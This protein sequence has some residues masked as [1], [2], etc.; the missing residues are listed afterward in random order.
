MESTISKSRIKLIVI[1]GVIA[2]SFGSIIIK[3]SNAPAIIIS[4]YR[5]FFTVLILTP[6]I[7]RDTSSIEEIKSI[8]R[9]NLILCILSGFF[10][11]MHFATWITSLKYTSINSSTIL[12]NTHPIFIVLISFFFIKKRYSSKAI[13]AIVI[14]ITGGILI[15]WGDMSMGRVQ[16][17]GDILALLGGFF[18]SGYILLGNY[19]RKDLSAK[20]YCY[21][22]YSF[23]VL[24]L[25]LITLFMGHS[26]F[27]YSLL[28]YTRFFGLAFICTILGH[29]VFNWALAYIDASF[30]SISILGEPVFATLWA[31]IIFNEIPSTLQLIGSSVV[32]T[33][34]VIYYMVVETK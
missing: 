28:E 33:G 23:S 21:I 30:V 19:V 10:L 9:R 22:V 13:L 17:I 24:F 1:L 25:L 11:A 32:L 6:F 5:M 14:T 16:L 29:T 34:I 27:N 3:S 20:S 7:L 15:S 31:V 4:T 12:V 2:V 18:V 26:L 8:S